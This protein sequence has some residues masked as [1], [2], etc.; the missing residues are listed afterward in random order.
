MQRIDINRTRKRLHECA[1]DLA[2]EAITGKSATQS[3]A[4]GI[5]RVSNAA[6]IKFLSF[7][8]GLR[9][10]TL[11]FPAGERSECMCAT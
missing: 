7:P 10:G 6:T 5:D 2:T 1:L 8:Q 9:L 3:A 11:R 4:D